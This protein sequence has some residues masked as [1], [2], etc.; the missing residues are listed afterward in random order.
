MGSNEGLFEWEDE[1]NTVVEEEKILLVGKLWATRAINI[2][3]AIDTMIKLWNPTKPIAGNVV[4]SKDKTFIFRFGTEKD[5]AKVLEGQPWHFD[6]FMWCF[7][8]P[9]QSGKV[10][11]ASL[12]LFPIWTR[13][14]DLPIAGRTSQ[15]NSQ[16][17]GNCL[18]TFM[19]FEHGPNPE[20]DRAIRVR[21][22]YDIR[23]PLKAELPIKVRDG[24]TINF[25][26][27]YERLPTYCY[28]CGLI[29]HGE[30]DC[31]NGP[32]EEEDLKFGEWLRASPWKVV[33]TYKEGTTSRAAR[34]LRPSFDEASKKDSEEAI[35]NMIA[36]LEN[37]ALNFRFKK[38]E[39]SG[40]KEKKDAM[41]EGVRQGEG[42][43]YLT[44]EGSGVGQS[45]NDQE[46]NTG[47]GQQGQEEGEVQRNCVL[48]ELTSTGEIRMED[49][50][51]GSMSDHVGGI[52]VGMREQTMGGQRCWTR[53]GRPGDEQGSRAEGRMID[54]R[55]TEG[56]SELVKRRREEQDVEWGQKKSKQ[57]HDGG[58]IIPEAELSG[59]EL[60]RVRERFD[61]FYGIKVDSVGRSGGLAMLWKKEIDCTFMS[62]SNHHMDFRVKG[63]E[64][65]WR[66]T[67]FYGWP[68]TAERHLSWELLRLLSKQSHLPWVCIG[69]FNEILF[70]TEMKG[71]SR[72]Q[73][74]MN[75]LRAVVD[76][77]G[78]RDTPWEGY[79]F[80]WD[81]GQ[82]GDANRQCML[83]RALCSSSWTDMFPYARLMYLNREWSDHA[84]I[85]LVLNSRA[86]GVK[87]SRCFRFEQ[88]WVGEEGC[89]EAVERRVERGRGSLVDTL[90]ECAFELRKWKGMNINK[91][92]RGIVN[93][94]KQLGRLDTLGR[95]AANV[96]QR[97][98]LVADIAKL[99]RQEEQYWRQRSRALWL[100]DGDKNTKFFH[101]RAGELKK[102]NF[103]AK[104]IDDEGVV[105][106][107]D[108]A[109]GRVANN[110][111]HQLFST[112]NPVIDEDV[113]EGVR[114]RVTDEMNETLRRDYSEEEVI[115]ALNQ[116]H[117]LK[118]PGPDGMNGLFYQTYWSTIGPVVTEMVLAILRGER[119]PGELNKTNIVLIPKK[120][121]PDKIRDF[122]PI[123]LCNVAYKLVSKVL[124]NRLM[125][126][127]G[128]IVSENQC[129]FTPGRAI[130]DNVMIAFE[131]FHYMK[132]LRSTEGFMALKLD[133]AKAYDRVEWRFLKR[134]LITMGFDSSWVSRVM[135]CVTSVSFSVLING[136]P[137]EEFRPSRGLRQ[138]DPL[139]PYLFILCAEVLSSLMRRAVEVRSLHGVRVA[140]NAPLISHLLFADDSIFFMRTNMEEAEA[141]NAILQRY[142]HASGQL[143]SLEKTTISFSKGVP[144]QKR[145]NLATRLGVVEVEEQERYLG[146]PTV[147]GRSKKVL[148]DILRDKLTKRLNGWR[149]KILSRAGR[150]VL[151]KA[152]ANSLPT[153]VMSIFKIPVNFCEELRSL[154]SRFWWGHEEGK[155][156]ISWVSWRKLCR[157]KSLGG[158]GFRDFYLFN[159]ALIGKQVWRLLT[160]PNGL[161]AQTMR[162]KYYP[163]GDVM[164][165]T[166]GYNPS[167]TWRGI[168]E[169]REALKH[170]WRKRIGDG[171][172]TR[173]WEDAWL[174]EIQTGRIVSPRVQGR[175]NMMVADL[176]GDERDGIYTVRSAYRT[177]AGGREELEIGGASN[178]ERE[179]WLWNRL[180]KVPVWPR[181]KLFFWQLCSEALATRANIASRVR[182]ESSFC[183][184]C[185]NY[186]ESSLHLFRD[187]AFAECVWE[188]IGLGDEGNGGGG[189]RDWVEARWRELGCR[190]HGLFMIGCWAIWEHRNKVV[191]DERE[192]DVAWVI[193]RVKDVMDEMEGGGFGGDGQGN[194]RLGR[195]RGVAR[196][197]WVIP[198]PEFV[199]VNVDAGLT[200]G[201]GMSVG[202]VCRDER[203]A[204]LWGV[205]LV[206]EQQWDSQMAEAVAILE[207]INE[208]ARR[209]HSK[210]VMES[211]CLPVIERLKKKDTGRSMFSLVLQDIL[212]LCNSFSSVVWSYTSRENNSVAH[213]LAHPLPRVVG[214]FVWSDVLPPA[215]N[216]AVCFDSRL[217]Q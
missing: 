107:G 158:M 176:I 162:A 112:D 124:A 170:G 90:E 32:Y 37:I 94:H 29:G 160:E 16:R 183:S 73:R 180:W 175:E 60:R 123:S 193:R 10:S 113:V 5:R 163:A 98:K 102:K 51:G 114:Q 188:G 68:V 8:V 4:D 213:Y 34:D 130:S 149:G 13:I 177:L 157:S 198:P 41:G 49:R 35:S 38:K 45:E 36:K 78:L 150:E 53:L 85:K 97:R 92:S 54:G 12:N 81:N 57:T 171:L 115:D 215:A 194:G 206:Q 142:E 192:V 82:V 89:V 196:E 77:C 121:A 189:I 118:A 65:E 27:K 58:V 174:P 76:E 72:P 14:Y 209:G 62:A 131:V 44:Q 143:V 39:Q 146:L 148:T 21:V 52:G 66:I 11:D 120:K 210:I 173:V 152:V 147:L 84:P 40:T 33:K 108:V 191:F 139:S 126:F 117:P 23:V 204:V 134:V 178:W 197:V 128:E 137:T 135:A 86:E 64:G 182:G 140:A 25:T 17:L 47:S 96:Q 116:M 156:G 83:D 212:F 79:N 159:M 199:K 129:A 100:K 15:L 93:R 28:G 2:K 145:N 1:G 203:G 111:F 20:L 43:S 56:K 48:E 87:G 185:N 55:M 75:N 184:L 110:Y 61:E 165:A 169:A 106:N 138:G 70:S 186:D 211:D 63:E 71:G 67:G 19:R 179:R 103:I 7:D 153:Y 80:S 9:N 125:P 18:G 127:L 172:S 200:D 208:A 119:S 26:V 154:I 144:I 99:R 30:K 190:E 42:R 214:R 22:L 187:C 69:D 217:I 164:S 104:L 3:A 202:V 195:E 201:E 88:I 95:T 6:K 105:R 91:I 133:M 141:V 216:N 205:S 74:Q 161:W 155:K 166:L 207:G 132:N 31:E 181:V 101:T 151:I 122:R 168:I 136:M 59:R 24:R 50:C 109:V 167:Y 46:E